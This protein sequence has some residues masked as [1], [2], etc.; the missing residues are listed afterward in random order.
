MTDLT[1]QWQDP[2]AIT[3]DSEN[4]FQEQFGALREVL[5]HVSSETGGCLAD[6]ILW[7][8]IL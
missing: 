5:D 8:E 3:R 1:F 2:E 7:D 4:A 6:W